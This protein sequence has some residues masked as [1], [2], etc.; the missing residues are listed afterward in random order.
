[1]IEMNFTYPL[2]SNICHYYF[3]G[4]SW[5]KDKFETPGLFFFFFFLKK[6]PLSDIFFFFFFLKKKKKNFFFF[7]FLNRK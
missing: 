6:K 2:N 5:V 3:K 4:F 1:M 7:F